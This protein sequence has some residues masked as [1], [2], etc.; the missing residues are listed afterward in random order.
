VSARINTL[1]PKI[2]LHFLHDA[3]KWKHSE[4]FLTR[5][6]RGLSTSE[7]QCHRPLQNKDV[8]R[9][10]ASGPAKKKIY[11]SLLMYILSTKFAL[12]YTFCDNVCKK[13]EGTNCK[14]IRFRGLWK[15]SLKSGDRTNQIPTTFE[16]DTTQTNARIFNQAYFVHAWCSPGSD[17]CPENGYLQ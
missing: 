15:E 2:S 11:N 14:W 8:V 10:T 5:D 9:S 6:W 13:L 7:V 4:L 16:R 12:G 3:N 1:P 17:L